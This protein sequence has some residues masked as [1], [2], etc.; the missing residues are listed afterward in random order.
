MTLTISPA[1]QIKA[2]YAESIDLRS[3][4]SLNISRASHVEPDGSGCWLADLSLIGGP[5]LGPFD[6]RSDALAVEL[7][8]LEEHWLE[9]PSLCR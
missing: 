8:W 6:L 2:I 7:R 1:G 9:R 3:L 5:M 4:G